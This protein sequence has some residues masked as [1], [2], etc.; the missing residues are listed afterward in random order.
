MSSTPAAAA[1]GR[2]LETEE[3]V[4]LLFTSLSESLSLSE[5]LEDEEELEHNHAIGSPPLAREDDGHVVGWR[6]EMRCERIAM[7]HLS[8]SSNSASTCFN[9]LIDDGEKITRETETDRDRKTMDEHKNMFKNTF[10]LFVRRFTAL[11]AVRS[12]YPKQ[13]TN[14]RNTN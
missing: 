9:W 11:I 4:L 12:K 8:H 5:E 13:S 6:A 10:R 7:N 3:E 14:D 2:P 1:A